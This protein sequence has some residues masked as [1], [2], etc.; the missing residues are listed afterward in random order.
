MQAF[1]GTSME[2][3]VSQL[4]LVPTAAEGEPAYSKITQLDL[5]LESFSYRLQ[6]NAVPITSVRIEWSFT[7]S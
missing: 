4:E 1:S 7:D 2:V 6:A 3:G 5:H